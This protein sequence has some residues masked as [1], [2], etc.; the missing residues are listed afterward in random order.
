LARTPL[1]QSLQRLARVIHTAKGTDRSAEEVREQRARAIE[2]R[3]SALSRRRFLTGVSLAVPAAIAWKHIPK[4]RAAGGSPRIA[5]IGGGIAG[6][7]A[8]LTLAD[9]GHSATI[10]EALPN[11]IGGRMLSDRPSAP[12]C[13][14]C[15]SVSRTVPSDTWAEGQTTDVFGE[16]IDSNH[17][18]ILSLASRFGLDLIDLLA[19]EPEGSTETYYFNGARYPFADAEVDFAP[20]FDAMRADLHAA[21]YP[22]TFESSNAASRELDAMSMY[23]W[24]ESRVPGGHS[25][26]M[27]QLLDVAYNI[28]FGAETTDQSSLNLIYLL[29][30]IQPNTF[31]MFGPS[32]ER[33]RLSGGIDRLPN[34][35]ADY[36]GRDTIRQGWIMEAIAQRADGSYELTFEADKRETV[37]ADYVVMTVPFASLRNLDYSAAGFD[38]LKDRAIREL[39]A[40]HN[41]K[42]QLQ[43]D[44]RYWNESG[45]W[46]ISNGTAYSDL[47]FQ[48]TWETTRGQ[49]GLAGILVNYTGGLVTDSLRSRHPYGNTAIAQV[50][51]DAEDFLAR[52]EP[53][54]PGLSAHW[55]GRATQSVPHIN[56]FWNCSYSYWRTG[57]Y[58]T[59]AGYERVRQGNVLF[60]G[61]HPSVDF[62][63]WMEG[64][65]S[66]GVRAG[67]ELVADLR[68]GG[69]K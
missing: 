32:D 46:G 34:A 12:A 60:A 9:A 64:G 66:E 13:G 7:S 55:N 69:R 31:S 38:A 29:G 14:A 50:Q 30:Y 65:A 11:R 2:D 52:I 44:R 25:S 20:V 49:P 61:E 39:G 68:G 10:Y 37:V 43:F 24:I 23:D 63:G 45:P 56:P 3:R 1:L 40:G 36:L 19:A 16:L 21:K 51:G 48:N 27:G 41:A 8:A 4:A 22:T 33:Y 18:T 59:I 54:F 62:Q 42:L 35:I 26:A 58:Q 15:H 47:G 28:E 53:V 17:A 67:K 5:I 6:L 57:Q